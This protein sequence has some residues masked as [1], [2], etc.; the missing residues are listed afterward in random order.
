MGVSEEKLTVNIED[1]GE[2]LE[3]DLRDFIEGFR[4]KTADALQ[5]ERTA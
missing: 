3:V 1:A 2:R 4:K 5:V